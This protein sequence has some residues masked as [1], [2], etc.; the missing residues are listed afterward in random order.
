MAFRGGSSAKAWAMRSAA[1]AKRDSRAAMISSSLDL[2]WLY[3]VI[4]ATPDSARM[5]SMPVA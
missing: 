1:G 2:K 4:L 3:R 5:R